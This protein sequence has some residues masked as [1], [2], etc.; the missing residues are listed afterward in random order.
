MLT[1]RLEV[2]N[3][4]SAAAH[5]ESA[6]TGSLSTSLD[7]TRTQAAARQAGEEGRERVTDR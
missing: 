4:Y 6:L 5:R 3:S 1:L 7:A 2:R